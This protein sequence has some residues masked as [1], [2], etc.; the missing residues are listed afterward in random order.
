MANSVLP[1]NLMQSVM[2]KLYNILVNGDKDVPKSPDNFFSWCPVG[3]P[4]V[5][6]DFDFLSQ[7]LRGVVKKNDLDV[8]TGDEHKDDKK[9]AT[10]VTAELLAQLA[11]D[12][13]SRLYLQAENF[14]RLVDFIPDA[15]GF[16]DRTNLMTIKEDQGTLSDV[17]EFT[18]RFSQ[19][20]ESKL[21]DEIE[22]K[23]KK[24]RELMVVETVAKD[25][26][27]D[28]EVKT[29]PPSPFVEAYNTKMYAYTDAVIEYNAA[30]VNALS[31][32]NSQAIH[33]WAMNAP[34]LRN[35]V[36][37]AMNAWITTGYKTDYE[38]IAAF[39]EQVMAR[40]MAMLKA[41]YKDA[42]EKARLTG[43]ASGS[44]FF[45]SS[46]VPGN[47]A[48]AK[49]WTGFSF[50]SSDY[51]S[52]SQSSYNSVRGG[53]GFLGIFGGTAS[54]SSSS[55]SGQIDTS[56]FSL[57]FEV[58]EVPIV[59]PWFKPHFLTSK[60]WRF[61]EGN[62]DSK[63]NFL[64]DGGAANGKAPKGLMPA[65]PTSMICI[66]NLNLKFSESSTVFS[67]MQEQTNAGAYVHWG[68]FMFGGNY[69]NGSGNHKYE[70]H[71]KDQGLWVDGMQV[72]G[73]RCHMLP[74]S[75]D[76]NPVITAWV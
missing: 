13:T 54:H 22:A 12:D 53:G 6:G 75:P 18:L 68:G 71:Q 35:K 56:N 65:Y 28:E 5:E 64:S 76:P 42:L 52:N 25:L 60:S 39:I 70:N 4:F 29:Y 40:D 20:M 3:I 67:W 63:G 74:K 61:D 38:K 57:T 1:E 9:E 45:Y 2:G 37:G 17:Y 73:F 49:S 48:K 21:S 26:V 55:Y 41:D 50:S 23:I 51:V 36:K 59:R 7:G 32:T 14:A 24:F 43:L 8:V 15:S 69:S 44:D 31:A 66:R 16:K 11:A 46:V 62:P 33:Y 10:P 34:A 72:I 27:T 19:V 47:F 30:R 58:T